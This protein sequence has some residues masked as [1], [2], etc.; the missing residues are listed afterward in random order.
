MASKMKRYVLILILVLVIAGVLASL[1]YSAVRR[2]SVKLVVV[3]RLS[4]DE[5]EAIRKEFLSSEVA[6]SYGI[7]DIEF[8]KVEMAL[9]KDLAVSGDVDLFFVGEVPVYNILCNDGYLRAI[10]MPEVLELVKGLSPRY[11]MR[12]DSGGICWIAP[13]R[14]VYGFIINERFIKLYNLSTPVVWGDVIKPSFSRSL[15]TADAPPISFPLPSRSGT[16]KTILHMILQKYGW[17]RGWE[18]LT[19]LGANSRIVD[20]SERARDEAAEGVVALAPA[21]IGYGI[22]AENASKGLAKFVIPSGEGVLYLSP[23]AIAKG[24]KHPRE[25][26]AF[27]LWLLSDRGQEALAKLFYYMPVRRIEGIRWVSELYE[28]IEENA[29]EYDRDLATSIEFSVIYYFESAIANP[30][31]D[32]KLKRVWKTLLNM[33]F[34]GGLSGGI[35]EYIHKIGRPL[36]ITDPET[37]VKQE[38]TVGYAKKINARLVKDPEFREEFMKAVKMA[39]LSRYEEVLNELK[40]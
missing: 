12:S 2:P 5:G 14:A 24:T 38:F 20:S 21:Y 18:I 36:T 28:S 25:A 32:M 39:A 9:W 29:Y 8:R 10:D 6:K 35:D 3:T 34:K 23:V 30:D 22:A 17:V 33:Y 37:G 1:G 11:F 7:S 27:I 31:T 13:A 26:Q 19:V 40:G 4:P 16:A 15:L